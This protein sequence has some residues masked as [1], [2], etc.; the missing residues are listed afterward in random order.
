VSQERIDEF[1]RVTGDLQSIHI[2]PDLAAAGPFGTIVAHGLLTLSLVPAAMYKALPVDGTI[3]NYGLNRVRFPAPVPAGSRVR[4]AFRVDS[5]DAVEG[6][7]QLVLTAT[8]ECE[9]VAKPAC[10]AELVFRCLT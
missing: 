4:M 8:V 1:A 9:G 7:A 6:G 10:V 2:D 5:V 3:V